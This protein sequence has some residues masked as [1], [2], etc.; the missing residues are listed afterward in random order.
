[1]RETCSILKQLDRQGWV[2][3]VT[4]EERS[5]SLVEIRGEIE[6]TRFSANVLEA[7]GNTPLVVSTM[8]PPHFRDGLCELEASIREGAS[9]TELRLRWSRSGEEGIAQAGGTIVEPTSGNMG[10]ALAIVAGVKGYSVSLRSRQNE[11]RK[12][13]R[14]RRFRR[15][16]GRNSHGQ[17]HG[18]LQS[19][20]RVARVSR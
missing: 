1:M 8:L 13:S 3:A 10:V 6:M 9:R 14:L 16:G 5:H 18:I 4:G 15:G 2:E 11:H 7:V 19:T 12:N 20:F 17:C